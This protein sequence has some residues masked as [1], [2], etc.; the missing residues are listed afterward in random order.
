LFT[1]SL[2]RYSM[3]ALA[4]I[5]LLS[6]NA[7]L[8]LRVTRFVRQ[9]LVAAC[10]VGIFASLYVSVALLLSTDGWH[11]LAGIESEDDYLARPHS[12]YPAPDYEALQ[13]MNNNLPPGSKVMMA[14]DGR[15]FY[16]RLTVIPAS[17]YDPQPVVLAAQRARS[18]ADLAQQLRQQGVTH[19]AVNLGEAVRTESYNLFSWDA[20]SWR[21]FDEFWRRYAQLI[22]INRRSGPTD[23]QILLVFRFR[24]EAETSEGT[25]I[26]QNPF[27]AWKPKF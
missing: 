13:W 11:V 12:Q 22:W 14:G 9:G 8:M 16:S 21:V 3:P 4:L 25:I 2:V 1:S 7:I 23:P 6:A 10:L 27:E 26:P 5:C 17:P 19:L 18:G 20:H 24:S 15:S